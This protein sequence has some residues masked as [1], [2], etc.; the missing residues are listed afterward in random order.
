MFLEREGMY[1]CVCMGEWVGMCERDSTH[2]DE[3]R[4]RG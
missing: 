3:G 2:V 1:E 4:G